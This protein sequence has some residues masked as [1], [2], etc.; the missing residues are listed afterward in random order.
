MEECVY[1]S[2]QEMIERMKQEIAR[3]QNVQYSEQI[4]VAEIYNI[5]ANN[6][7]E[8]CR[9]LN[10]GKKE[11]CSAPEKFKKS[12]ITLDTFILLKQITE[13]KMIS[14]EYSAQ[15]FE[16]LLKLNPAIKDQVERDRASGLV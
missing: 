15:L 2:I 12:E 16:T 9:V 5:V 11:N 6:L 3:T 7:A 14:E 4:V 1:K 10:K 13:E 8:A